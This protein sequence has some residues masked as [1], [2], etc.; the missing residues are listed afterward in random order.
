MIPCDEEWN[1]DTALTRS[2]ADNDDR[3][4]DGP[5]AD[6][7]DDGADSQTAADSATRALS[8][9]VKLHMCGA[10]QTHNVVGTDNV[11]C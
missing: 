6:D 4:A 9:H 7:T 3:G 2:G 11:T 8:T 1:N 10:G 5:T